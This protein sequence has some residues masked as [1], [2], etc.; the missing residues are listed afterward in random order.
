VFYYTKDYRQQYLA[1]P[2]RGYCGIDGTGAGCPSASTPGRAD[3]W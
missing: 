2:P 1:K 3:G